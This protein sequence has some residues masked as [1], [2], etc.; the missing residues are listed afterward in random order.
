VEAA[1]AVEEIRHP[2]A[3]TVRL[4]RFPLELST[5]RAELRRTPPASGEHTDEILR[6]C[7]YSDTEI[8]GLRA[9]GAV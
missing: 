2:V 3:G 1:E 5:G 8:S 9:A 7:G 4:L 6:E